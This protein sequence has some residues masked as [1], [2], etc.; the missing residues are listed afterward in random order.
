[1]AKDL[2]LR[3][4]VTVAALTAAVIHALFPSVVPDVITAG[5][6]LLAFVPWLAPLIKSVE[7]PGVGKLELRDIE[8]K[9]EEAKG[10]ALSAVQKADLALASEGNA[11]GG[12]VQT[13]AQHRQELNTLAEEYNRIREAQRAGA[14]RTS[15]MAAVVSKMI[16][17]SADLT[18]DEIRQAL[19]E[20][21]GGKRLVGYAALYAHPRAELIDDLVAS[22]THIEDKPFGQYWGIQA[23]GR[24]IGSM[25]Q[26]QVSK[27]VVNA[28]QDFLK[29]LKPGTDR[30][31]ELSGILEGLKKT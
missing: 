17:A 8:R 25:T 18:P 12:E 6:L 28:L 24:V 26:D 16:R 7:V 2:A 11:A 15:A 31:Y 1:M 22:V 30:Y 29:R 4:L 27:G 10:A 5:F 21:D 20:R 14:A 9:A 3:C 13:T 23:I 19:K